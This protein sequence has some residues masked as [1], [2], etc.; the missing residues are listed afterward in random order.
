MKYQTIPCAEGDDELVAEKLGAYT[1]SMITVADAIEDELVV[2][3]VTDDDG[4]I[5][6]G[7]NLIISSWKTAELDILWVNEKH[8]GRGI[9]SALIREAECAARERG[10]GL[11]TLGTFDFQ[12]RPLYEKHGFTVCG[13]IED[14][15]SAGHT[16]YD[17]LK[18]LDAPLAG[19][20]APIPCA[21]KPGSEEDAEFIDDRLVEYNWS[22]VP[23]IH[24]FVWTG[25]K[26]P[27]D[28][29]GLLAACF[30]GVNFWNIA[31]LDMLWV[32]EAV[33]RQGLG[34]LL[35]SDTEREAKENGALI[36]LADARDWNM[37]FFRTC[38][39]SVYGTLEDHPSGYRKYKVL[40][41]L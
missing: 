36:M 25:R 2:F 8:R 6:A 24:D 10:C 30:A 16:H 19:L 14:C 37:D 4:T 21:I 33:R 40:K 7:C 32:D 5:L 3:K 9:G 22:K 26:I 12:A 27:G 15:P 41:R 35:L 11:M 23:R 1:D 13:T 29:G 34:S 20:A 39:Y 18:R 28:D 31:F 38:G 17:M